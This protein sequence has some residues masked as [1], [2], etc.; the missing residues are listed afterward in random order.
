MSRQD[1]RQALKRGSLW[2]T[3]V[4]ARVATLE[5]EQVVLA[6]IQYSL[7]LNHG[8]KLREI[9]VVAGNQLAFMLSVRLS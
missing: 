3:N 4:L 9:V 7:R 1:H 5:L 8:I 2:A 6:Q